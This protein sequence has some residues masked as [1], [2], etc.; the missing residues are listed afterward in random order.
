MEEEDIYEILKIILGKIGDNEI[1]WRMEGSANLMIQ[2]VDIKVNDLDITTKEDMKN[3]FRKIFK[4]FI[5]KD[6]YNELFEAQ[7][8]TLSLKGH[9]VEILCRRNNDVLNM[10]DEVKNVRWR[11]LTIPI[12]PLKYA[13]KFYRLI[14]EPEKVE[15]IR[16]H[17][18][19]T[20]Q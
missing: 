3:K 14:N 16:K 6:Y 17:L 9:E 19:P 18:Q 2:G 8:L 13:S 10:F 7:I 4:D 1:V 15:V 12:L 20:Y 11:G 5:T